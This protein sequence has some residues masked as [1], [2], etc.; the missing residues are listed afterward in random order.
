MRSGDHKY[1]LYVVFSI[2]L[3]SRPFQAKILSSVSYVRKQSAYI[4]PT[5]LET[6]FHSQTKRQAKLYFF[7][8]IF[9]RLYFWVSNCK[10]Q[11]VLHRKGSDCAHKMKVLSKA[12]NR[13]NIM[14]LASPILLRVVTLN[15]D[16]I[17]FQIKVVLSQC[18]LICNPQ[19]NFHHNIPIQN[20]KYYCYCIIFS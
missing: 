18:G 20:I 19:C 11:K 8:P 2:P 14:Y 13:I 5:M 12:K 9:Y 10:T 4:P 3:L 15:C 6:Q 7:R 16:E 17:Q 1:P